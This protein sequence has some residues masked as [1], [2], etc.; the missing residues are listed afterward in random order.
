MNFSHGKKKS[1]FEVYF[2]FFILFLLPL[3]VQS[4]S[5]KLEVILKLHPNQS[6]SKSTQSSELYHSHQHFVLQSCKVCRKLLA[7][8]RKLP[9]YKFQVNN[10]MVLI[11]N[12]IR[13]QR[14]TEDRGRE[15]RGGGR[16]ER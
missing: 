1:S 11:I 15:K 8:D 13:R 16:E 7:A 10:V 4:Q 3:L 14:G 12:G 5:S 9:Q 6:K 2:P